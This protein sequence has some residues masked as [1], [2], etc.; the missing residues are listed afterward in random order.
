[1]SGKRMV[2]S[3]AFSRKSTLGIMSRQYIVQFQM[4]TTRLLRFI[5]FMLAVERM[6]EIKDSTTLYFLYSVSP[7][8]MANSPYISVLDHLDNITAQGLYS[9]LLTPSLYK[10]RKG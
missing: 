5:D 10:F 7:L 2:V 8:K 3:I 9:N 4:R 6:Q 1:M